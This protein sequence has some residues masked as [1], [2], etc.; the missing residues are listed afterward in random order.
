M[1]T[2]LVLIFKYLSFFFKCERAVLS[3][4]SQKLNYLPTDYLKGKNPK[5]PEGS[6]EKGK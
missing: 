2:V 4:K 5:N 6:K 3:S 1:F